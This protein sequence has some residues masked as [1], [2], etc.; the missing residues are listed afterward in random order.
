MLWIHSET[1]NLAAGLTD[2][3]S[4]MPTPPGK[5]KKTNHYVQWQ[6]LKQLHK[7]T[8]V[9]SYKPLVSRVG[10]CV[11]T[12]LWTL[13]AEPSL[14]ETSTRSLKLSRPKQTQPDERAWHKGLHENKT[15]AYWIVP[16]SEV[17]RVRFICIF[18]HICIPV[19]ACVCVHAPRGCVFLT[20]GSI[21]AVC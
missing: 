2:I 12:E 3:I 20:C 17:E 10:L 1:L 19:W 7:T 15:L 5:M 9:G 4:R 18:P 21:S 16:L 8:Y 6:Q 13:L 11:S 14:A